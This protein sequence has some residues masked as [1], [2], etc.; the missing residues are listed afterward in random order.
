MRILLTG[1]RGQLG[2]Q[3]KPHLEPLGEVVAVDRAGLDLADGA[4]LRSRL[5]DLAP[6]VIVNCA[7]Y[8]A[9]DRAETESELAAAV[10]GVAPGILAAYAQETGG[11]LIHISTDYVFDGRSCRPYQPDAATGPLGTYGQSKLQ[12]EL[13]IAA[14]GAERSLIL[15]TAW[16]YGAGGTG[17]F[18][19][20]MLRLGR[21]RPEVRV[22]ADQIGSPTWTGDLAIAIARLIPQLSPKIS[23]IYHY[24]NSG[25]ASWYDFATAIFEEAQL[26]GFPLAIERVIPIATEDYPTPAQRPAYSVLSGQKIAPLLGGPAPHWRVALRHMLDELRDRA[27]SP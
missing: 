11:Y 23:G 24:T 1:A 2:E 9:V 6:T 19:K 18:V 4:T 7:A 21:D 12:G 3:V 15:R 27:D 13:A 10:N 26:R 17:N 22:V 5:A 14:N 20:T 8:T 16:V 25:A